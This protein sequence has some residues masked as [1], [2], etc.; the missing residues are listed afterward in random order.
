[1]KDSGLLK[2]GISIGAAA[3]LGY[4]LWPKIA[5]AKSLPSKPPETIDLSR[6]D[7]VQRG[8][9][10]LGFDPGTID[11]KYGPKTKMAVSKYQRSRNLIVDSAFGPE[12]RKRMDFDLKSRG[13]NVVG[14]TGP[15]FK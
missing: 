1:M 4:Y 2:I 10:L 11:G 6:V 3:I 13:L 9:F 15:T 8:L 5:S 7:G 14:N 12:S